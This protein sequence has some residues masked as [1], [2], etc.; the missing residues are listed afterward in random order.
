MRGRRFEASRID[1]LEQLLDTAVGVLMAVPRVGPDGG[2]EPVVAGDADVL[3]DQAG[4]ALF[5]IGTW[6]GSHIVTG[7]HA[8]TYVIDPPEVAAA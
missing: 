7:G 4:T 5:L 8:C 3:A 1:V 6:S 2:R